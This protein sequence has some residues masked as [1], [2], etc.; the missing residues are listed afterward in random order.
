MHRTH[1]LM[2]LAIVVAL[3][4]GGCALER[5]DPAARSNRATYTLTV[6]AS[7]GS[8]VTAYVTDGLLATADGEGAITQPSTQTTTQSP[9]FAGA[10]PISAGIAAVSNLGGK[11]IDAYA[12]K[13]AGDDAKT[14]AGGCEGGDCGDCPDCGD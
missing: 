10:D 12:A 1:T 5:S 9:E 13:G 11:A 2:A 14:A 4:G 7:E 8:T 6:N 3:I